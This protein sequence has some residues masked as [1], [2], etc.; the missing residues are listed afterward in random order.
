MKWDGMGWDGWDHKGMRW[1]A[2][3]LEWTSH[4]L[5][6]QR[7]HVANVFGRHVV[8]ETPQPPQV[9]LV[10]KVVALR[11]QL[12]DLHVEAA[13]FKDDGERFVRI[14]LV[15]REQHVVVLRL[16]AEAPFYRAIVRVDGESLAP[17]CDRSAKSW[18]KAGI[19]SN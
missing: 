5:L 18:V 1:T 12:A 19:G 11:A 15:Q 7:P 10:D 3:L 13:H 4:F 17:E 14:P 8:L 9:L 2:R 16:L 6:D